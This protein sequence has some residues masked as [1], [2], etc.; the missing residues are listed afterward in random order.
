MIRETRETR[1]LRLR[2]FTK[3][4]GLRY[5]GLKLLE[6]FVFRESKLLICG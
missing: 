5:N 3:D 2:I 4:L 6:K 1:F